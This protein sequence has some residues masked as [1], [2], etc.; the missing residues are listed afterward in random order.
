MIN[1]NT[2]VIISGSTSR[3]WLTSSVTRRMFKQPRFYSNALLDRRNAE[4][5]QIVAA[6][7]GSIAYRSVIVDDYR[8]RH[9]PRRAVIDPLN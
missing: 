2:V 4:C 3:C 5:P 9:Q 6:S 8:A 1:C 7:L